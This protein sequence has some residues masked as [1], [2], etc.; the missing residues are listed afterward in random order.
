[1]NVKHFQ[2]FDGPP[3]GVFAVIGTMP[4]EHL[5]KTNPN[6]THHRF[7]I[8]AQTSIFEVQ[9]NIKQKCIGNLETV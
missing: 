6:V 2:P 7:I 1:M 5:F 9:T 8:K 4:L 3:T